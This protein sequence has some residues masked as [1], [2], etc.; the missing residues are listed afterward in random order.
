MPPGL[1]L[2]LLRFEGTSGLRST[3]SLA[4]RT[5]RTH[6]ACTLVTPLPSYWRS[7][8]LVS[9]PPPALW[10]LQ[11]PL[12]TDTTCSGCGLRAGTAAWPDDPETN[13][14]CLD[15]FTAPC[16]H[17]YHSISDTRNSSNS[18]LFKVFQVK[19]FHHGGNVTSTVSVK[20]VSVP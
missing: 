13:Q 7:H 15:S 14:N 5:V 9:S 20:A 17:S 1:P 18:E 11:L 6:K 8:S 19:L 3:C 4:A 2:F 10:A 16:Y 12:H